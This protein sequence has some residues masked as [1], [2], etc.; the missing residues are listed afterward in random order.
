M[1]NPD[2]DQAL[3]RFL[4]ASFLERRREVSKAGRRGKRPFITISRQAGAGGQSL[5]QVIVDEFAKQSSEPALHGW[6][7]YDRLICETIVSDPELN[8][9]L[10]GLLSE[11]YLSRA[12]DY[13]SVLLGKSFQDDVQKKV[14]VAIRELALVG[15]TIL[16]GRGGSCIT[17]D[18]TP[19]IHIRLVAPREVRV[20]RMMDALSKSKEETARW[21]DEHDRGRARLVRSRFGKD[22]DDP[23]LYDAVWNTDAISLELITRC[24]AEMVRAK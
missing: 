14:A 24:L 22:I 8:V 21:V 17:R 23:L 20:M 1:T 4:E 18:I 12:E 7:S 10:R 3:R 9:S 2:R 15:H 6:N 19:G 11:Q 16:V 5:A 13:V